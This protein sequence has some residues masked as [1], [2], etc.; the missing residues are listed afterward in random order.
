MNGA[1]YKERGA[2]ISLGKQN[3]Q[4]TI[5]P[6]RQILRYHPRLQAKP[7]HALSLWDGFSGHAEYPGSLV[8]SFE[9]MDRRALML[10]MFTVSTLSSVSIHF[11]ENE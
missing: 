4:S 7:H 11:S 10:W 6:R 3:V 5:A 1:A 8:I 9:C 2:R